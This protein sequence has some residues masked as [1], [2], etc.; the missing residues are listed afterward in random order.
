V[1][2]E[3]VKIEE[4]ASDIIGRLGALKLGEA[5][6]CELSLSQ[7]FANINAPLFHTWNAA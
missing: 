6:P 7:S 1:N 3:V 4:D 5:S 2:N